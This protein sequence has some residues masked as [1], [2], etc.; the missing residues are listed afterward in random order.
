[1]EEKYSKGDLMDAVDKK[2]AAHFNWYLETESKEGT[3]NGVDPLF[4]AIGWCDTENRWGQGNNR[5]RIA[6]P[7][8]IVKFLGYTMGTKADL[9]GDAAFKSLKPT[10]KALIPDDEQLFLLV[11][12]VE[13]HSK[14][15]PKAVVYT[16]WLPEMD[17]FAQKVMCNWWDNAEAD[18]LEEWGIEYEDLTD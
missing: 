15:V 1:M 3:D 17:R 10:Q 14:S 13:G 6:K 18:V 16:H 12:E 8:T 9:I 4:G 5:Q 11:G 7:N 2:I